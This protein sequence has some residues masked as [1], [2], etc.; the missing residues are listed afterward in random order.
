LAAWWTL[1][2]LL[3]SR[4]VASTVLQLLGR[5]EVC[6]VEQDHVGE[7]DLVLGLVAVARGAAGRA[8][9]RPAVTMRVELGLRA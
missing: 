9:R 1:A 2:Y 8:W 7:G 4:M 6:L 3:I 5:D